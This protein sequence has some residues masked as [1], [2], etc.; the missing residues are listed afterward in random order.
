MASR[1][2]DAEVLSKQLILL[3]SHDGRLL[4]ETREMPAFFVDRSG[5]VTLTSRMEEHIAG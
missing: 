4:A 1:A 5:A 2:A 3:G